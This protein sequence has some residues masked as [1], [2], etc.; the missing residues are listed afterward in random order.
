MKKFASF[1]EPVN[2]ISDLYILS[3]QIGHLDGAN[4]NFPSCRSIGVSGHVP[5]PMVQV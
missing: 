4:N 1:L 5:L 2:S 3:H